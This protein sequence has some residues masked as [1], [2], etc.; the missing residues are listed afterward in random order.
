[1][2]EVTEA[3]MKW[4]VGE[5]ETDCWRDKWWGDDRLCDLVP[6]HVPMINV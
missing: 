2:K 1:M 5:G 6:A 4:V 3:A